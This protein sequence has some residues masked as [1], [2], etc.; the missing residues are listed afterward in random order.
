MVTSEEQAKLVAIALTN[1]LHL[2]GYTTSYVQRYHLE[3]DE[4]ILYVIES[5]IADI[6]LT[7]DSDSKESI[8]PELHKLQGKVYNKNAVHKILV[9]LKEK[10]I[11]DSIKVNV[12]NYNEGHDVQLIVDARAKKLLYS[13]EVATVPIYGL[14]PSLLLSVPIHKA[15]AS[16]Q[17]LIGFNEERV[18]VKKAILDYLHYPGSY[19]WH[20]GGNISQEYA[21]WERYVS[22][23]TITAVR[24]FLGIGI[25]T[26]ASVFDIS[27]FVYGVVSYYT[28][29]ENEDAVLQ[30]KLQ[31]T[32]KDAG[33]ELRIKAIDSRSIVKKN[34]N[35]NC[36][37]FTGISE[38]EYV[39]TSRTSVYIPL[40]VTTRLYIIPSGYSFYTTSYNRIYAEYVFD[41][42]LLGYSSRYTAT[43]SRHIAKLELMYE[44]I[45]E[46]VFAEVFGSSCVYKTEYSEWDTTANYG[47]AVD[48]YYNTIILNIGCAWN[49]EEN[50]GQYYVFTGVRAQ[51]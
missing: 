5:H 23:F 9:Q 34:K 20:A 13:F 39:F 29:S 14:T 25:F 41:S 27:S 45:Y 36:T 18:T 28:V 51:F 37:I 12:V 8:K 21:V 3:G 50:F 7:A 33:L 30:K 1:R 2:Y 49:T 40:P 48:L 6:Q 47:V 22:D 15:I 38:D 19:G 32:Y 35:L 10:Y 4:C 42:Y 43:N 16:A 24:P 46:F 17:G 44:V 26:T 31:T 11:L